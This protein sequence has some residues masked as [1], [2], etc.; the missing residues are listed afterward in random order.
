MKKI[1]AFILVLVLALSLVACNKGGE[2][3]NGDNAAPGTV[4]E[5]PNGGDTTNSTGK[6]PEWANPSKYDTEHKAW[7]DERITAKN[8]YYNIDIDNIIQAACDEYGQ[9]FNE[10]ITPEALRTAIIA[11]GGSGVK[12]EQGDNLTGISGN[13]LQKVNEF[14]Q[15]KELAPIDTK[16]P[17]QSVAAYGIAATLYY[18]NNVDDMN[19][20]K[21]DLA[22]A[23]DVAFMSSGYPNSDMFSP[24][25]EHYYVLP[26]GE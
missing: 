3:P 1:L 12:F 11:V 18:K 7:V 24:F 23:F 20:W 10:H 17:K 6:M 21:W 22:T 5:T 19:N 14:L 4:T 9:F 26:D 25:M 16:D 8:T 2:T 15:I 13:A